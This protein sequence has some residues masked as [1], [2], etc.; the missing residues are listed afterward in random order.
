MGHITYCTRYCYN[1]L[2]IDFYS[3]I[4]VALHNKRCKQILD[5]ILGL[6]F[7]PRALFQF[8]LNI[9]QFEYVVKEVSLCFI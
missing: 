2:F 6:G 9:A 8:L 7:D 5:E 4:S 1:I 3:Y